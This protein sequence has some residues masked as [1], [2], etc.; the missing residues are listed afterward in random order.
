MNNFVLFIFLCL[1]F[2]LIFL[3]NNKDF[4][5][6]DVLFSSGFLI[7]SFF[8]AINTNNWKYIIKLFTVGLIV[9]SIIIF[10]CGCRLGDK[11]VILH[12]KVIISNKIKINPKLFYIIILFLV[13]CCCVFR[14][15]DIYE[16]THSLNILTGAIGLYRFNYHITK[17]SNIIKICDAVVSAIMVYEAMSIH[18]IVTNQLKDN[19]KS[20]VVL[21]LGLIYFALSSSRIEII[22]VFAYIFVSYCI[23][24]RTNGNK[25]N[26]KAIGYAFSI[27]I[28]VFVVF[29]IAGFLTG[30]SQNQ[31]S[32]FD[33][34]S[35]YAGSS[36]GALDYWLYKV[37]H[38]GMFFG[39]I[40]FSG[41]SNFL[42]LF[43]HSLNLHSDPS[44]TF[45]NLGYMEHTT[46]VYTCL[47]E[48]FSDVG[49]LW[50]YVIIFIEGFI[51]RLIHKKA[52]Y[53]YNKENIYLYVYLYLTP[54]IILS[55]VAERFFS[56]FF[57]FSTLI[58]LIITKFLINI[59]QEEPNI[60]CK[61]QDKN[62]QKVENKNVQVS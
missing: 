43:G 45:I 25:I 35:L 61:L 48:L 34:I 5:A 32:A 9:L 54:L 41:I 56:T 53:K 60:E 16:S 51:S 27:L 28:S 38:V 6:P 31:I 44:I 3:Y 22:Y 19:I 30:K 11:I 58:Y 21:L 62:V 46:N 18:N 17:Y 39:S 26:Y 36:I 49:F 55:S 4:S 20:I 40:I 47:T 29:F 33:N 15:L 8:F 7:S 2:V 59:Q 14:V 1:L 50:T 13:L 10:F 37:N 57:T 23:S 52:L 42:S 12:R 24:L